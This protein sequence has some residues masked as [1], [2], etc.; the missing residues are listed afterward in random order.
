MIGFSIKAETEENV[1]KP[2]IRS[3]NHMNLRV[4]IILPVGKYHHTGFDR[5]D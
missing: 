1:S 4:Q 2:R 3:S 5:A